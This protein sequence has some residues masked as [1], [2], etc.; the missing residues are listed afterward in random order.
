MKEEPRRSEIGLGRGVGIVEIGSHSLG[1]SLASS[2]EELNYVRVLKN[3]TMLM[4][5]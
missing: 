5:I 2:V 3:S 1:S 4:S